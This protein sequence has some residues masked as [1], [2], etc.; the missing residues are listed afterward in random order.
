MGVE[1]AVYKLEA[2]FGIGDLLAEIGGELGEEV[3]VFAGGGFGVEV[4]LGYLA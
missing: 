3:A 2:V 4:Q 1:L